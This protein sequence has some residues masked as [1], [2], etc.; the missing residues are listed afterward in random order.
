M[1]R[2]YF[3]FWKKKKSLELNLWISVKNIWVLI[4]LGHPVYGYMCY[5]MFKIGRYEQNK[6][7]M[8]IYIDRQTDEI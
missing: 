7:N 4:F 8:N 5:V 3:I 1:H 6:M 2:I